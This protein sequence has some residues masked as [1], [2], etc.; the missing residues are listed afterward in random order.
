VAGRARGGLRLSPVADLVE[1]R[2]LAHAMTLKYGFLGLPQGG[3]KAAV[4]CDADAG[5]QERS[6]RLAAFAAAAGP[7]MRSGLYLPDADVGTRLS[8]IRLVLGC[9]GVRPKRREWRSDRSGSWT[10]RSVVAALREA[11]ARVARPLA[12]ATAA[13]EGFGAVGSALAGYLT[14]E[15]A[16]VV[17]VSTA[18]GA[19]FDAQGLDVEAL[20][21]AAL[22][23]GSRF[24]E[25]WPSERLD[26]TMLAG[27]DVD[28][29]CPCGVG[30]TLDVANAPSVRARA[31]VPGANR[32]WTPA[33]EAALH[34]RGILCVPDFLA[35]CG[36]VLGGTMEFAGVPDRRILAFIDRELAARVGGV[37][38][39]AARRGVLPRLVAEEL[40]LAGHAAARARAE[41]RDARGRVTGAA[42]ELHRRGWLPRR[43]VGSLAPRWFRGAIAEPPR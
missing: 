18:R 43:I 8:E 22:A 16:R 40:A 38:D 29:L 13:I 28:Y 23:S 11:A 39:R 30:E 17:A 9:A 7:L 14:R 1:V 26:R 42:I 12:G 15:G 6:A 2:P 37:L 27:L 10:A 32:P 5:S 25:S 3:A 31:V 34:E 33:A 36:G 21:A 41:R 4:R 20:R 35:N 19:V 24:V